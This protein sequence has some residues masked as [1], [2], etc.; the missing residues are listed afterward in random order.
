MTA[1]ARSLCRVAPRY[2]E[3]A[4]LAPVVLAAFCCEYCAA[5]ATREPS[6]YVPRGRVVLAWC[7]PLHAGLDGIEPWTS[8]GLLAGMPFIR[9]AHGLQPGAGVFVADSVL[10]DESMSSSPVS[11]IRESE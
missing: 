10:A 8:M 3:L 6:V 11:V 1:R 2:H 5:P 9:S 4:P 7:C